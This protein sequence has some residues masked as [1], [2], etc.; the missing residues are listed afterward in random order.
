M[1]QGPTQILKL[2]V[3]G[4][5]THYGRGIL[6]FVDKNMDSTKYINI[7]DNYLWPVVLKYFPQERWYFMDDNYPIHRSH[8]VEEFKQTSGPSCSKLTMLLVND[9]LK[10]T[11]NDTQISWNFLLKKCE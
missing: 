2:M 4:M 9:S 1:S 8:A 10:F 5:I 7:L 6:T 11:S 3:W